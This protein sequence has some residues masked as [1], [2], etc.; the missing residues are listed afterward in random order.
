MEK[1]FFAIL[2]FPTLSWTSKGTSFPRFMSGVV[3]HNS[4]WIHKSPHDSSGFAELA[5]PLASRRSAARAQVPVRHTGVPTRR[6]SPIS[7]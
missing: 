1:Y 7:T 5:R 3:T 4:M 2:A 6:S